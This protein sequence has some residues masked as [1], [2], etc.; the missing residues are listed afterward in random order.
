MDHIGPF[1]FNGLRCLLGAA[2]VGV[3]LAVTG[4]LSRS[5]RRTAAPA[6]W[7]AADHPE[8]PSGSKALSSSPSPARP[9]TP[10]RPAASVAPTAPARSG[11]GLM[12]GGV[13]CGLALFAAS[14]LQQAGLVEVEAGKAGFL[15]TLYIVLVPVAGLFWGRRAGWQVWPAVGLSLV[16]LYLLCVSPGWSWARGD[17][18]ILA[19]A[20]CWTVQILLVDRLVQHGQ[21]LRLC[22]AQFLTAGVLS[23]AVCPW[24]DAGFIAIPPGHW[25]AAVAAALPALAFA[26]ILSSG[27]AF[28][29][30]ALGQRLAPPALASLVMSLE[31][32]FA[33]LAGAVCLG[34]RLS[35]R[36]AAGC[37]LMFAAILLA[38]LR[39][40]RRRP[41][42]IQA[43]GQRPIPLP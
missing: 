16:G 13:V 17:L 36:E 20:A 1:L 6:A 8:A 29:A 19:G 9:D 3:A 7:P 18:V 39:P 30:Q 22:L 40:T 38:Q 31:A 2:T 4:R 11:V 15:T 24:A 37:A 25:W 35:P 21:A 10:P 34:E 41:T 43:S 26:G 42:P 14:N 12:L 5:R 28:T 27:V 33:V 32:P 23:L